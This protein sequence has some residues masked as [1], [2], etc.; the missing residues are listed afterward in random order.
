MMK[1]INIEDYKNPIERPCKPIDYDRYIVTIFD[2][3]NYNVF[4]SFIITPNQSG[5]YFLEAKI[6]EIAPSLLKLQND[7]HVTIELNSSFDDKII[8]YM[9]DEEF[10]YQLNDPV[11]FEPQTWRIYSNKHKSIS[12]HKIPE[13]VEIRLSLMNGLNNF[14]DAKNNW[15][16]N[17]KSLKAKFIDDV[18]SVYELNDQLFNYISR[19]VNTDNRVNYMSNII[20]EV[21][22]F[23][24]VSK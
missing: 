17:E 16:A 10:E 5:E 19:S 23:K 13:N 20:K 14:L 12:P 4:D 3:R 21:D 15:E 11:V 1:K 2:K 6:T 9:S 7:E 8:G 18:K 24:D 22:L